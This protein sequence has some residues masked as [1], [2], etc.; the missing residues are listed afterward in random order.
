VH[1]GNLGQV[2]SAKDLITGY[3]DEQKTDGH[4]YCAAGV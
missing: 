2:D 4:V 1:L 3:Q